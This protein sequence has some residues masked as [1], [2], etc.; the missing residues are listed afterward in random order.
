MVSISLKMNL[1]S[2]N[3]RPETGGATHSSMGAPLAPNPL[4]R[5]SVSRTRS[6][7]RASVM[8]WD[9]ATEFGALARKVSATAV[10][11]ITITSLS[12]FIYFPPVIRAEGG[13]IQ[14]RLLFEAGLYRL[15]LAP[16]PWIILVGASGL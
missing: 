13:P 8:V 6:V 10:K 11:N 15:A 16:P 2:S 12:G 1:L 5:S 7:V 4:N 9:P 3:E 14:E